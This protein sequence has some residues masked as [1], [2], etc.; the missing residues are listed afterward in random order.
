M[1]KR[2]TIISA[3]E[4]KLGTI[5]VAGGYN[6]DLQGGVRFGLRSMERITSTP[7]IDFFV[8]GDAEVDYQ[9]DNTAEVN[10]D[11]TVIGYLKPGRNDD[12]YV[13]EDLLADIVKVMHS[14]HTLGG[15]VVDCRMISESTDPF[16][17]GNDV[18]RIA[19][20]TFQVIYYDDY[21]SI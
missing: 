3:I 12:D 5:S 2:R 20:A 10:M 8:D 7:A 19:S 13:V 21:G 4:T 9:P 6:Y 16:L 14:D 18:P 15:N 11:V 1:S 17:E